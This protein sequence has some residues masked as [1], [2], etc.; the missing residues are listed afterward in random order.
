MGIA[1]DEGY[2]GSLDEK[3]VDHFPEYEIENLTTD[4]EN[5]TLEQLLEMSAGLEWYELE[6]SYD[7]EQNTFYQWV[8]SANRINFVLDQPMISLPGEEYSYNTGISHLLSAIIQKS[9]GIRTDLYANEKIFIPLGI[10]D[11]DW[12]KDPE[13]YPFGGHTVRLTPRDMAKFGYLFLK[14]GLWEDIQIVPADW[15][16]TSTDAHI[17]RKYIPDFHYGY[18]WWVKENEYYAAVGAYGQWIY[19]VPDLDLVVVFTNNFY[20]DEDLQVTTP[21]RLLN[22]YI[23]PAVNW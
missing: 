19:V 17:E 8:R 9:T 11:Y 5:V 1:L 21:E 3:M 7:D 10:D 15:V 22:T 18:H 12:M 2:I 13:G 14:Q 4:K 6:Y 23:I 16:E 20:E